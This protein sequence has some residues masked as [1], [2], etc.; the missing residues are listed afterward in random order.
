MIRRRPLVAAASVA[1][2]VLGVYGLI[3]LKEQSQTRNLAG[4]Q[5]V[6][7]QPGVIK[8]SANPGGTM[9][10]QAGSARLP[11]ESGLPSAQ[12]EAIGKGNNPVERDL[13]ATAL[14]AQQQAEARNNYQSIDSNAEQP[15]IAYLP[16]PSEPPP[17]P[18]EA[19]AMPADPN[20]IYGGGAHDGVQH[21]DAAEFQQQQNSPVQPPQ[22]GGDP[23]FGANQST[24]QPTDP[25]HGNGNPYGGQVAPDGT[26]LV[27]PNSTQPITPPAN[28]DPYGGSSDNGGT[29]Y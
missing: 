23:Q 10:T 25:A 19:P 3:A 2:V 20:G 8:A 17:S 13:G 5:S 22:F 9:T 29:S 28:A 14:R 18:P 27:D 24:D 6:D 12:G 15:P 4:S 16:P 26:P 7:Q 1:L 21:Y 11:A